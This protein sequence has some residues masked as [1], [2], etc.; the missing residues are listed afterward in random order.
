MS[1]NVAL[2]TGASS[3][4]GEATAL[5]FARRGYLVYAGAR[6]MDR[7]E[8]LRAHGITP[9]SLDVTDEAS[10][11]ATVDLIQSET[12]R[13]DVLV[14][15]AGYGSYG[16][17]EDVALEEGRR[18]FDVNL[19]GA[20]QLI[21]L[22]TP[23]MRAQ[24]SGRIINVTSI[25]GKIYSPFGGWYH[26]SKF[27][28]EG[29][30]DVLRAELKPFGIDVVVIEPGAIKTEWGGIAMD[31][32]LNASAN[33]PYGSAIT[34]VA[35]SFTSDSMNA[36]ASDPA[37]IATTIAT[38]ATARRPKTRYAA[39]SGARIILTLR[40]LLSDRMFDALVARAIG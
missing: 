5:E 18:Q 35:A 31:S 1:K 4:I 25:G 40:H 19:F 34:K 3:G 6:R 12:G 37:V 16:A 10:I 7:M 9:V 38:A 28:L 27:A 23:L 21:R 15:N 33:G 17:V 39:G 14:N 24:G 32:G 36:R 29:M 26:G 8:H 11:Q 30:S 20:I 13:I 2:I 22:V